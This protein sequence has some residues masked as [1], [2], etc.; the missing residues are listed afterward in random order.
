MCVPLLGLL[1]AAIQVG[2]LKL[3]GIAVHAAEHDGR[4]GRVNLIER[5]RDPKR[6]RS[7][8]DRA[9]ADTADLGALFQAGSAG[10]L[11]AERHSRF[12]GVER[13]GVGGEHAAWDP[14]VETWMGAHAGNDCLLLLAPWE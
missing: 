14:A 5:Q 4:N 8:L 7:G 9:T 1:S 10:W 2:S 12:R 13:S 3:M 6:E 11:S